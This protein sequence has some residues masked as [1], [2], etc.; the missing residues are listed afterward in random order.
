MKTRY[1]DTEQRKRYRRASRKVMTNEARLDLQ[2]RARRE[3]ARC[4]DG[5]AWMEFLWFRER[6][7]EGFV[8]ALLA[9]ANEPCEC[10]VST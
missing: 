4:K 9:L 5:S 1:I 7:H 6:H 3:N 8:V 2:D 10:E